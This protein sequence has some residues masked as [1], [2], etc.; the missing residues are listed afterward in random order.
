MSYG[1]TSFGLVETKLMR[2]REMWRRARDLQRRAVSE[3]SANFAE[4]KNSQILGTVR[5]RP[6]ML[7]AT[8]DPKN[9]RS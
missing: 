6:I 8:L 3:R 7:R 5:E 2:R 9:A 1:A 4:R